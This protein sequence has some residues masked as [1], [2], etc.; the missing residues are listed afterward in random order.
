MPGFDQHDEV[1]RLRAALEQAMIREQAALRREHFLR[2]ELTESLNDIA[3]ILQLV[4]L[5]ETLMD[6]GIGVRRGS[7]GRRGR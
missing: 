6:S 2:V 3:M 1:L 5:R 4:V 7:R